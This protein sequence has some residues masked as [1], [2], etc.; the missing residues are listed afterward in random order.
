MSREVVGKAKDGR[1]GVVVVLD[2]VV[3]VGVEA[4]GV[5]SVRVGVVGGLGRSHKRSS[6][7]AVARL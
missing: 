5:E 6:R 1:T 3:V 2:G 7:R 4:E